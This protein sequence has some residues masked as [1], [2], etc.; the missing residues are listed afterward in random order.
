[1][2][3]TALVGAHA[4]A[5]LDARYRITED[6]RAA[7][8]IVKA[9]LALNRN[10]RNDRNSIYYVFESA[11]DKERDRD[12]Y[13]C[14]GVTL[15][16]RQV[17]LSVNRLAHW[18]LAQGLQRG[19]TIALYLPNKPAYPII[20]LACLAID[21]VPAF[22]NYNLTGQG[23]AHCVAVAAPKLVLFES[24][25]SPAIADVA[26]SL[27]G[28]KL[29]RWVDTFS[30]GA[31]TEKGVEGEMVLD[32][33]V[34]Q[35]M[36]TER[37]PDERR[38]GIKWSSPCCL[39]YTSGTTGLPK[40]ALTLHGRCATAFQVW[41]T[42]NSFG[43]K[44]RIYTPMPLYHST[45]AILAVG[46]AWCAHSTVVIGRKFSATTFWRDVRDSRANVVQYVGEVLRYL[47]AR[48][49]SPEDK[50]HEV[51]LA[52]GNGCRPDVWERFR[53]RFGVQTISEFFA[54][55]EGNGS[56][57]NRNSNSLGAGAVGKE[58]WIVSTF[59]RN[60]QVLLRVDP[61]TEEPARGPDGLA[62]RAAPNEPG[63]LVIQID[64]S[65]PYQAFAGYHN[66]P[67]ATN[68]KIMRSVLAKDDMY[69]RT[70]DLLR[71]D[72]DGHWYFADRLGDTF[73][74]KSENV[75]TADVAEKLGQVVDEANVY[76]VLV[77]S[78]DGRAG[79]A[80]IPLSSGQQVD[81]A[82]LSA[83]VARTLP[84]YAQPLFVRL[85]PA[86]ESTGTGKQLKVQLRNEGVDPDVVK[87]EVW[88]LKPGVGYTPFAKEDWEALK[89]GKVKL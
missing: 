31:A 65:S 2:A 7:R 23:L 17:Q 41:T 9:R 75:S 78:H 49:P 48:P 35:Q 60:K 59:Q 76:G 82:A 74:W 6:L 16:W 70:G 53:E 89:A 12:C 21:V 27:G 14:E 87:D 67:A 71:R 61:L 54:S 66:N 45:A 55:S 56:L 34:L 19:D 81:F 77:P 10:N 88:W 36:S 18:L 84:K 47:L 68:K 46:V 83:H 57:F 20:W 69:F 32:E 79:C 52:Y 62:I 39:I 37:I 44:T 85:V 24:D 38:K 58:G 86:L 26:A 15:S 40:A 42:L 43:P 5:Y 4:L 30:K 63:E 33:G 11:A 25:L 3:T 8:G 72:A 28:A 1:M 51:R 73:R 22:I 64:N 13:V 80:A 29:V 50:Q